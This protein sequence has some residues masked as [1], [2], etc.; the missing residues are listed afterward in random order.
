MS[1]HGS[2]LE[3]KTSFLKQARALHGRKY[4]YD[5]A[6]YENNKTAIVIV[7]RN[8]PRPFAFSQTP[9]DHLKGHGCPNCGRRT[10]SSSSERASSF[11][12]RVLEVHGKRYDYTA[13]DYVDA[14]TP[15]LIICR[16]HGPFE[17][18]PTKHLQGSG[19]ISCARP[20]SP[21]TLRRK[22]RLGNVP[23]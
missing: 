3:R 21:T 15:V 10:G 14:H 4:S 16:D 7:C 11:L 18:R 6:I 5:L 1:R 23:A 8:H 17:Q 22:A 9:H 19:C 12:S 2:V 20:C 13:V